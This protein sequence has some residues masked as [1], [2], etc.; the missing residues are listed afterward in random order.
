MAQRVGYKDRVREEPPGR[1]YR[2]GTGQEWRGGGYRSGTVVGAQSA[3][4]GTGS[5]Y[6]EGHR[7]GWRDGRHTL[8]FCD[9]RM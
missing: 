9:V 4:K 3:R 8:L 2:A 7:E 5:A 1:R 6:K